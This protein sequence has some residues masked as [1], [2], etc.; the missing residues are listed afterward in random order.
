MGDVWRLIATDAIS[1]Q[2]AVRV[3]VRVP[4]GGELAAMLPQ[5]A[6]NAEYCAPHATTTQLRRGALCAPQ[7]FGAGRIIA[8]AKHGESLSAGGTGQRTPLAVHRLKPR[9][10]ESLQ[11]AAAPPHSGDTEC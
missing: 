9:M 6:L 11:R 2:A 1:W 7:F 5:G 4:R 10:G 8:S 3:L